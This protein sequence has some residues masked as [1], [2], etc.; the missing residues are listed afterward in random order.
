MKCMSLFTDN[1]SFLQSFEILLCLGCTQIYFMV[2]QMQWVRTKQKILNFKYFVLFHFILYNLYMYV[3]MY[4]FMFVIS[5]FCNP[6]AI[7]NPSLNISI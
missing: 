5:N 6:Q 7:W 4:L 2:H 3:S 1:L